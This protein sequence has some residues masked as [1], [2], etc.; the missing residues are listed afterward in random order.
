MV[1]RRPASCLGFL[2][3]IACAVAATFATAAER[4]WRVVILN[5][6]DPTLPAFVAIDRAMRAAL[7]APGTHPIELYLETLDMMRF[8]GAELEA[9]LL[10][11]LRKKYAGD[12]VDAVIAVIPSALAFAE[13]Y[14]D[15]IWP[16]AVIIFHSVSE[17]ELRGRT[18]APRTTGI[19]LRHDIDGTA[20]LALRLRPATRHLIVIGGSGDYDR[21]ILAIAK[22]QLGS[23]LQNADIEYWVDRRVDD[24]VGDVARL[25]PDAAVLLLAINR[26]AAGR[27]FAARDALVILRKKT[28]VPI[29]GIYDTFL[30]AGIVAGKVDN[31]EW[32]GQRVAKYLLDTLASNPESPPPA[33]AIVPTECVA[34]ARELVRWNISEDL[35]PAGCTV[36]F[37]E[38]SAWQRYRWQIA[39]GIAVIVSQAV[40]IMALLLQ[41][42][43]RQRVEADMHETRA[44]LVHA[45]RLAS[46]GELTASIAHEIKQPLSAI[47]AH[48]ETAEL[49]LEADAPPRAEIQQIIAKIRSDDLRA[50]DVITRLR[51][52][53]GKHTMER[54][55]VDVNEV[56]RDT[57]RVLE[58]EARRRIVVV[59]A[60]LDP[61][62]PSVV[63][64]RVHLQQVVLNL[65]LNAMDAM[66]TIP[67]SDRRV[68]VATV[69]QAE[70]VEI[71]VSDNGPGI[72]PKILGRIFHSFVT[73]KA[74]GLGLG[75]SIA[76]SIVEAHGGRIDAAQSAAGGAVFRVTLPV[77]RVVTQASD[78]PVPRSSL[79]SA[80]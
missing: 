71:M 46:M 9:E 22:E 47:L 3:A 43:R 44:E 52:L 15:A 53:L 58:A 75:L 55:E 37:A 78:R 79:A 40:L 6:S 56:I 57:L 21:A 16:G 73:T 14:R 18:L 42:R 66:A 72:D 76:R 17:N 23:R 74:R 80:S 62:L 28:S 65:L 8:P 39:A 61:A 4:P 67:E 24:L 10:A 51:D 29:F 49:L 48:A 33:P 69:A 20:A 12:P 11:L 31:F 5:G 36:R 60:R 30:G 50:N 59:D 32:R 7:N 25:P 19:A 26:D 1:E 64:D 54:H 34:D 2:L 13:R 35:L 38:L 41:R 63:G 77:S 45:S 68:T 70:S 27:T